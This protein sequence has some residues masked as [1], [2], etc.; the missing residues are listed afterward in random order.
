MDERFEAKVLEFSSFF[1]SSDGKK[2]DELSREGW[3]IRTS[4]VM[5]TSSG[6]KMVVFLQRP[7]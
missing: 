5:P 4:S 2:L 7:L 6:A 3:I 1:A